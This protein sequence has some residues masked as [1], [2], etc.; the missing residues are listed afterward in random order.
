MVDRICI[1]DIADK[2]IDIG[3]LRSQ[4]ANEMN[5]TFFEVED[6]DILIVRN[7]PTIL[8]SKISVVRAL[9]RMTVLSSDFLILRCKAG[10]IPEAVAA[11][12]NMPYYTERI[13]SHI[14]GITSVRS[15]KNGDDI[16]KL[17]FPDIR[18]CQETIAFRSVETEKKVSEMRALAESKR[19]KMNEFFE[20]ELLNCKTE[21]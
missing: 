20:K 15:R 8:N 19:I 3:K 17:P 12:L 18:E 6:G 1:G 13:S 2:T 5:G 4:L 9:K 11:V 10:Y 14:N 7:S 21:A 16:L